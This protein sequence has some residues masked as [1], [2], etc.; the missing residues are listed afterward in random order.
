[1]DIFFAKFNESAVCFLGQLGYMTLDDVNAYMDLDLIDQ[2]KY[3]AI[4][5]HNCFLLT[6][7]QVLKSL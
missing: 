4:A 1:M 2:M 3:K 6:D 5:I 7:S